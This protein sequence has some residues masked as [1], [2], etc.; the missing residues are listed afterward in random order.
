MKYLAYFL[1]CCLQVH[2]MSG[3]EIMKEVEARSKKYKTIQSEVFMK[4]ENEGS[5]RERYFNSIKKQDKTSTKN[6]I[7]FY[8]PANIKGTALLTHSI[9]GQEDNTQWVYLPALKSTTQLSADKKNDSFMGS[10]FSYA[11]VA[12]RQVEKDKHEK[13]K[14]DEKYFYIRSTP[15]KED[16]YSKLEIIVDR[17]IFVPLKVFFF[18]TEGETLKILTNKKIEKFGDLHLV[19]EALM[20][21][22]QRNSQSTLQVSNIVLDQNVTDN[23]VGLKGLTE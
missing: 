11:D 9:K 6:L 1:L 13:I 19:T 16:V 7:K 8:K 18:N 21:N 4:I 10:D 2:A 17:K 23:Q 20:E 14:E 3:I 22:K 12:G 5:L 15:K